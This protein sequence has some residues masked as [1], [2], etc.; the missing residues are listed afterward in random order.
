MKRIMTIILVLFITLLPVISFATD[1]S[2]M[3]DDELLSESEKAKTEIA[4]RGLDKNNSKNKMIPEISFDLGNIITGVI[5]ITSLIVSLY[6]KNHEIRSSSIT[7][8][9]MDWIKDVRELC[10]E[11]LIEFNKDVPQKDRLQE[12]GI[13]IKLHGR[14]SKGSNLNKDYNDLYTAIDACIQDVINNNFSEKEDHKELLLAASQDMLQ[15]VWNRMKQEAGVSKRR[16]I[17][18]EKKRGLQQ[19]N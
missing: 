9:R 15:S 5:A 18:Y 10:A 6:N 14:S 17:K 11:F 19:T 16:E 4:N 1:Y 8:Q 3:K 13:R 12:L 2:S 7:N